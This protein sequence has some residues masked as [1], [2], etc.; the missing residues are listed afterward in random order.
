ME[1]AEWGLAAGQRHLE[2]EQVEAIGRFAA[3]G[4]HKD[5]NTRKVAGKP[6]DLTNGA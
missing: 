3:Y 5:L 2:L 4:W 1:A 6:R